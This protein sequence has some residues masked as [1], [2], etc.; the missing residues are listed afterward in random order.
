MLQPLVPS[1]FFFF[2][3]I[4]SWGF[5]EIVYSLM[6]KRNLKCLRI[7]LLFTLSSPVQCIFTFLLF[8]INI[9]GQVSYICISK[10]QFWLCWLATHFYYSSLILGL[11]ISC[12]YFLWNFNN[13]IVSWEISK[14]FND[15]CYIINI[16]IVVIYL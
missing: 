12:F 10:F 14:H 9:W 5:Q 13:S 6:F 2:I 8:L 15:L 11:L 3:L 1:C 4:K 16:I 7:V